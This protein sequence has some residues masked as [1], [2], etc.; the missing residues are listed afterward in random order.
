MTKLLD[1]S[2]HHITIP[3]NSPV[4]IGTLNSILN[5]GAEKL[6]IP[7]EKIISNL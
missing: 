3:N 6:K 4:K 2:E 5:D 1:S 7:K